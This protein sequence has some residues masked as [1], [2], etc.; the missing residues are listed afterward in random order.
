[1]N[2]VLVLNN[3]RI[4]ISVICLVACVMLSGLWVRSFWYRDQIDRG[5]ATGCVHCRSDYGQL[6]LYTAKNTPPSRVASGWYWKSVPYS[7]APS[8]R[9]IVAS[10]SNNFG[11]YLDRVV[12]PFWFPVLF[13]GAVVAA[14]WV[15]LSTRFS[16]RALLI[17]MTLVAIMLGLTAW[18]KP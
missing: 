11:F 4:A 10:E 3:L 16:L 1:M 17:V 7:R 12:I 18:S 15:R 8:F 13:S 6:Q 2:R 9:R 14:N 5:W